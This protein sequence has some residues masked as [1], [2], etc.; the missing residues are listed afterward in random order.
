MRAVRSPNQ[1]RS[2]G[3]WFLGSREHLAA[4]LL[5]GALN[6][7]LLA[8]VL[9]RNRK[10]HIYQQIKLQQ[11]VKTIEHFFFHIADILSCFHR[12][13]WPGHGV[14][15]TKIP[16][17]QVVRSSCFVIPAKKKKKKALASN[18][19]SSSALPGI[20]HFSPPGIAPGTT[21][22]GCGV[23]QMPT[24]SPPVSVGVSPPGPSLPSAYQSLS[25]SFRTRPEFQQQFR[26]AGLHF[27]SRIMPTET[28]FISSKHQVSESGAARLF[29]HSLLY[30]PLRHNPW[31][32]DLLQP[33]YRV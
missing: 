22:F 18:R 11:A 1:S 17:Q 24:S 33:F 8:E 16:F 5:G 7:T 12:Y 32:A 9:H 20:T 10:D 13:P 14:S 25:H 6:C 3:H 2:P 28:E 30:W 29:E 26:G 31:Q 27:S 15:Y 4:V 21:H 19:C 23:T